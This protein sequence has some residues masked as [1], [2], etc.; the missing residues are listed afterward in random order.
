MSCCGQ[1]SSGANFDL[2]VL[3]TGLGMSLGARSPMSTGLVGMKLKEA[4]EDLGEFLAGD[5][6]VDLEERNCRRLADS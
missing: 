2:M 5:L 4:G 6:V 1:Q 3:G